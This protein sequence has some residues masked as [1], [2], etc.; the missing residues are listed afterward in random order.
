M[1]R[2]EVQVK[3]SVEKLGEQVNKAESNQEKSVNLLANEFLKNGHMP[4]DIL[5]LSDRQVEG[6]YA[7][8]Y[9][10]YQTGRYKDALQ[11]FR[12]LIMLNANESKYVLGLAAC[13]HLMKEYKNAIDSYTL[14][15]ILDP[16]SPI[17][18]Y[19]MSDCFLA[20][21]DKYSAIVALDMAIK[22]AGGKA[23]FQMLKDRAAMTLQNLQNEIK[24]ETKKT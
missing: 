10:F 12:L 7:Q 23:E 21:K 5:N 18:Y 9:N 14:C 1:K 15:S 13:L 8:G 6:L 20:A 4:K 16:E 22:R 3:K 11:I 19:H 17:P 24:E 2:D